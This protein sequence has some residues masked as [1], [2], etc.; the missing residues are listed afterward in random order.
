MYKLN[1]ND[2]DFINNCKKVQKG[3]LTLEQ[4]IDTLKCRFYVPIEVKMAV[5]DIV[6]MLI[7]NKTNTVTIEGFEEMFG[8]PVEP[9]SIKDVLQDYELVKFMFII[10]QYIGVSISVENCDPKIY[11]LLHEVGLYNYILDKA[12][13]DLEKFENIVD[14]MSGLRYYALA[15]AVEALVTD[16]PTQNKLQEFKQVVES[17]DEDKIK[18]MQNIINFNNPLL[19]EVAKT[20]DSTVVEEITKKNK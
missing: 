18:N 20:L 14:D 15:S 12:S 16:L 7:S 6:T 17:I 13:K 1:N 3:K 4:L 10:S 8:A 19:G 11:D 9:I 2:K 5:A